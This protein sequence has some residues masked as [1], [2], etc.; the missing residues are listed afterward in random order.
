VPPLAVYPGCS[1]SSSRLSGL[2]DVRH[3]E[4][5]GAAAADHVLPGPQQPQFL[6]H[7]LLGDVVVGLLQEQVEGPL[8][9]LIQAS[10]EIQE[11]VFLRLLGLKLREAEHA[12]EA[13]VD[14]QVGNEL[15][16]AALEGDIPVPATEDRD[17]QPRS[18]VIARGTQSPPRADGIDDERSTLRRLSYYPA[19]PSEMA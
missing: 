1:P 7:G 14:N 2:G 4:P 15:A 9:S 19:Q 18:G 3:P 8:V 12:R 6:L 16:G 11:D 5:P 10:G 13:M 17:G